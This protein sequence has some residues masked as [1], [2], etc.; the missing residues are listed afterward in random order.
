MS[1][2][3][4]KK[5]SLCIDRSKLFYIKIWWETQILE[6]FWFVNI[7]IVEQSVNHLLS[8]FF[9][10]LL[11]ICEIIV[12]MMTNVVK[13][14]KFLKNEYDITR[15]GSRICHYTLVVRDDKQPNKEMEYQTVHDTKIEMLWKPWWKLESFIVWKWLKKKIKKI[16]WWEKQGEL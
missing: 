10:D 13:I 3:I 1:E 7:F 2:I 5:N 6:N 9:F 15:Y 14:L 4:E 16:H 11:N 8:C 12:L